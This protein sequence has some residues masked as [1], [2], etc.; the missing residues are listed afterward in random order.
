MK[1]K[2]LHGTF[3]WRNRYYILIAVLALGVLADQSSKIWA[4]KTLATPIKV[5]ASIGATTSEMVVQHFATKD[6]V[7]IPKIFNLIYK[8][9]PAAAFSLGSFLPDWFRMPFLSTVS[10]LAALFFL[11]WFY[12]LKQGEE[13]LIV[14]IAMV[15]AGAIGNLIDRIRLGYVIDFLDVHAEFMGFAGAHWPTFNIAD[16]VIVCGAILIFIYIVFFVPKES[17]K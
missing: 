10:I 5:P 2:K 9:N 11:W 4:Q 8:E 1:D 17:V 7:V 6:I 13:L 12:R 15:L 16:S 14:A 3:L